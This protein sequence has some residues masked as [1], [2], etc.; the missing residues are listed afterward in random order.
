VLKRT[1]RK[2]C[3]SLVATL[4]AE[5][6][7]ASGSNISTRTL[8]GALHEKWVS[9]ADQPKIPMRNAKSSLEWSKARLHWSLEQ[10]ERSPE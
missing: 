6:Q 8:R 10:W 9:M 4:T 2:N 7:T 3:L 5:F 1:A